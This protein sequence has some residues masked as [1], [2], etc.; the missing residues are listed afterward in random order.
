[1]FIWFKDTGLALAIVP[2]LFWGKWLIAGGLGLGGKEFCLTRDLL[3]ILGFG[4][5]DGKAGP[6]SRPLAVELRGTP[7]RIGVGWRVRW[8]T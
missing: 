3:E 4:V 1:M 6:S 7:L 8:H 2:F 5:W